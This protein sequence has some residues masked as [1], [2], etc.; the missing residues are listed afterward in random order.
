MCVADRNCLHGN[1]HLLVTVDQPRDDEVTSFQLGLHGGDGNAGGGDKP[2][3]LA[4]FTPSAPRK[5]RIW[6]KE[7]ESC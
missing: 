1:E 5:G 3:V 4:I 2:H 7:G 6:V